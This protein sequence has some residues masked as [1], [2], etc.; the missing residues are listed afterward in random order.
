[1]ALGK[2]AKTLSKGQVKT[3]TSR[4]RTPEADSKN[5][6]QSIRALRAAGLL[7]IDCL[8][9]DP[10]PVFHKLAPCGSEHES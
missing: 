7:K 1:M 2:Q 8:L 6:P 9:N 5:I 3:L 10:A 4:Q